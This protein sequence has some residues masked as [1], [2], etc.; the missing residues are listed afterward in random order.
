MCFAGEN[1][2]LIVAGFQKGSSGVDSGVCIDDVIVQVCDL[3]VE[4]D[5]CLAANRLYI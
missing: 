5:A 2:E 4:A 3:N 1:G